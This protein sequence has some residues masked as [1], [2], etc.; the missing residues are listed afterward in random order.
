MRIRVIIVLLYFPIALFSQGEIDEQQR[1][2]FRD[3]STFAGYLSTNGFGIGYRYA[4]NL[5]AFR[6]IFYDVD[7]SLIKHS[8]ENK[9]PS[10][11]YPNGRSYV[12]GKRNSFF[13]IR[14]GI[15]LQE[16]LF[17]KFDRGGVAIRYFYGVGPTLGILKP[18]YYEFLDNTT[19]PP[20]QMVDIFPDDNNHPNTILGRASF[21]KGTDE[22]SIIPGGFAKVGVSFE[23]SQFDEVIH[24]IET[25]AALDVFY[26]EVPIMAGTNNNFFFF[27]LYVSYRFGKVIDRKERAGTTELD[28]ILLD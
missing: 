28:E 6:K 3:E 14:G 9:S 13:A 19:Y 11:I 27:S 25:G 26:K 12:F 7:A 1:I 21:F 10:P 22:L 18:I 15:G 16:E 20:S 24:A 17:R 8:K 4:K 5:N 2:I 23:F